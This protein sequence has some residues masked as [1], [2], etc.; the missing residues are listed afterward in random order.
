M[1]SFSLK[2]FQKLRLIT[3]KILRELISQPSDVLKAN[4][5]IASSPPLTK[6]LDANKKMKIA[7]PIPK[8]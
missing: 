3:M 8:I 1:K 6:G 2:S 4:P 5:M 7:A